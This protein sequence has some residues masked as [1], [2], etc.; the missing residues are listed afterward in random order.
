MHFAHD[1]DSFVSQVQTLDSRYNYTHS[2]KNTD[3]LGERRVSITFRQVTEPP[4]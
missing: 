1:L 4:S 2:I 3:L